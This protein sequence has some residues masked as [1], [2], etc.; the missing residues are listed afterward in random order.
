[1]VA[2]GS[3]GCIEQIGQGVDVPVVYTMELLDWATG[4]PPPP[5]LPPSGPGVMIEF[6]KISKAG[7]GSVT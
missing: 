6:A 3:I 1:L 5:Q 4:G 7:T 2:V